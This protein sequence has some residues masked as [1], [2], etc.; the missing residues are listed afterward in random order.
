MKKMNKKLKGMTLVE[1]I[2]SIAIFAV[3][4]GLLILVGTHIDA[5]N[6]ATNVLKSKVSDESPYAA[7]Q[8]KDYTDKQGNPVTLPA[9]DVTVE[10]KVGSADV[11][12]NAKKYGTEELAIGRLSDESKKAAQ[13]K[14]NSGL[15]LQFIEVPKMTTT[16]A[17]TTV[18]TTGTTVT[19]T[20]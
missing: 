14:A 18:T 20:A 10:V 5:T 2:I 4:G 17:T 6:K 7:N 11:K 12:I 8:I 3:M 19:T 15:N 1:M 9:S 16:A 13:K